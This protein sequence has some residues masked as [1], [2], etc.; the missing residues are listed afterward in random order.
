MPGSEL[1]NAMEVGDQVL[2][3]LSGPFRIVENGVAGGGVIVIEERV[4][5]PGDHIRVP[6]QE[7]LEQHQRHCL[8]ELRIYDFFRFLAIRTS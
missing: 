8:V 1:R 6:L 5:D 2:R 3:E 7:T 4:I